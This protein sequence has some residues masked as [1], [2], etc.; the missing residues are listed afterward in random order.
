MRDFSKV[1]P[2]VWKSRKFWLLP[3]DTARL[4]Y[5]YLLTSPHANSVGCYDLNPVYA[6]GDLRW[7]EAAYRKAIDSLSEVGLIEFDAAENTVRITNWIKFNAPMNPK[8]ALGML[9]ALDQASSA[10]LKL[11]QLNEIRDAISF[12]DSKVL[13]KG[14]DTLSKQ[15]RNSIDTKTE[16]DQTETD[17]NET[18]TEMERETRPRPETET[19]TIR[20]V[21]ARANGLAAAPDGAARPL[22]VFDLSKLPEHLRTNL[23]KRAG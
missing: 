5:L 11:N 3:D 2:N 7:T 16:T 6:C 19:K 12:I 20:T 13:A 21:N 15:Y 17:Q 1:A 18:E 22:E 23:I 10:R 14:I 8:H 4:A 9:A